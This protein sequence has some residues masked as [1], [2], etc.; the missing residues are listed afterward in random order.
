[1]GTS[2]VMIISHVFGTSTSRMAF[3]LTLLRFDLDPKVATSLW[4][5][6]KGMSPVG[7]FIFHTR[8]LPLLL[9]GK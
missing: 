9:R 7:E 6:A 2:G 8:P 1:M 3:R 5:L 4:I